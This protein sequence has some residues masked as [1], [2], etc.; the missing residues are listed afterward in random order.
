MLNVFDHLSILSL[1]KHR[2]ELWVKVCHF[3]HDAVFEEHASKHIVI[4][5][6]GEVVEYLCIKFLNLSQTQ[7]VLACISNRG[8]V[9]L[10]LCKHKGSEEQM[11]MH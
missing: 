8:L 9:R 3:E 2:F 4:L 5:H 1:V 7:V 10:L 6:V 11:V